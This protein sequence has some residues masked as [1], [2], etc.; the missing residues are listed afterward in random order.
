MKWLLTKAGV[1]KSAAAERKP[2]WR[3]RV[4]Y[5]GCSR[6]GF[7]CTSLVQCSM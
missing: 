1:D 3:F 2:G 6:H 4:F 7:S 5:T